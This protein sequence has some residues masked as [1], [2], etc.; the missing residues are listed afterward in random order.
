MGLFS[1]SKEHNYQ[2]LI[3]TYSQECVMNRTENLLIRS[4]FSAIMLTE[5]LTS[6]FQLDLWDITLITLQIHRHEGTW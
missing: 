1:L 3:F 6:V 2:V 4:N 5:K